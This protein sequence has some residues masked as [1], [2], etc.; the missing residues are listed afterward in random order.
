MIYSARIPHWTALETRQQPE[1]ARASYMSHN[2]PICHPP[3]STTACLGWTGSCAESRAYSAQ[4]N[5]T[6]DCT[7]NPFHTSVCLRNAIETCICCVWVWTQPELLRELVARAKRTLP[8]FFAVDQKFTDAPENSCPLTPSSSSFCRAGD[9]T[10]VSHIS[11]LLSPADQCPSQ[12]G[13]ART[14]EAALM[15]L[16]WKKVTL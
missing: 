1:S 13:D 12:R 8:F 10:P 7:R 5:S 4:Q 11:P 9:T 16:V 15:L 6:D 3:A 2:G 14:S